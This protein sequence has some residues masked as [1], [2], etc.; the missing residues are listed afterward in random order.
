MRCS[1]NK[2]KRWLFKNGYFGMMVCVAVSVF[3]LVGLGFAGFA[4][5]G[6]MIYPANV[7]TSYSIHYT[8]LYELLPE[9]HHP[10]GSSAAEGPVELSFGHSRFAEPPTDDIRIHLFAAVRHFD[11]LLGRSSFQ[12]W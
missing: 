2:K 1:Q 5:A 8:K 7:I 3:F 6:M 11:L 9:P 10:S 4:D 12:H